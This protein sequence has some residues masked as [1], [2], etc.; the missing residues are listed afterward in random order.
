M[1]SKL[2]ANIEF[3][4][5]MS[6]FPLYFDILIWFIKVKFFFEEDYFLSYQDK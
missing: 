3:Q 1:A 5:L 4:L 6:P 2:C